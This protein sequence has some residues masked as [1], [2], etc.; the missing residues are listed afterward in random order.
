LAESRRVGRAIVVTG[1]LVSSIVAACSPGTGTSPGTAAAGSDAAATAATAAASS[2]SDAATVTP[3]ALVVDAT[4]LAVLP[5]R[6]A[7]IALVASPETAAAMIADPAL[8]GNASAV[9]VAGAVDPATFDLA[10]ASV[11]RLRPGVYSNEFFF[12]WRAAYDTAACGQAG[13]IVGHTQQVLGSYLVDV[14]ACAQGARTYHV[15]IGGDVIIS[16]TSAGERRFG[17]LMMSGLRP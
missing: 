4:L 17:D 12:G 11:I 6:I 16:V 8:Q 7:D 10:I 5:A 9:A 14:T 15:H 2:S 3:A 13:G 1:L